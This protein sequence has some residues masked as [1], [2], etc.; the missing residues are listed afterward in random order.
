[1]VILWN[2]CMNISLYFW[3]IELKVID[4][5]SHAV[6]LQRSVLFHNISKLN[7]KETLKLLLYSYQ[8][9]SYFNIPFPNK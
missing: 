4:Q 8:V 5:L 9:H 2:I 7:T 6:N 3:P 1:M